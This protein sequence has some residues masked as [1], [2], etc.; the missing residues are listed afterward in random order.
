MPRTDRDIDPNKTEKNQLFSLFRLRFVPE[1][2][3]FH[4]RSDSFGI[5][6]EQHETAEDLRTSILQVENNCEFENVTAAE[7]IPSKFLSVIGR[8]AGNYELK[9]KYQKSNIM[10]YWMSENCTKQKPSKDS[11]VYE[12]IH[13]NG[14]AF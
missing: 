14:Q 6:R 3:K 13:P 5:T 2:N 4:C 7:L 9:K 11:Q 1:R 12:G 10:A 8:A